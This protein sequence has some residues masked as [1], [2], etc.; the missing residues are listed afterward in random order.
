MLPSHRFS[1][2]RQRVGRGL[3]ATLV[4][5]ALAVGP[6]LQAAPPE[7]AGPQGVMVHLT[8][9]Q[10]GKVLGQP[11]LFGALGQAMSLRWQS[12]A[13]SGWAEHWELQ[14]STTQVD[15]VRL[16]LDTRLSRGEPLKPMVRPRLITLAGEPARVDVRSE[17]GLHTLSIT[18][19]ARLAD[20]PAP[21]RVP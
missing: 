5:A 21:Q 7:A 8:L 17:D 6:A 18:L 11:R 13:A 10:D 15:P 9:E 19:V 4:L 12:D 20:Q 2:L 1:A 16:L 3:V 14:L